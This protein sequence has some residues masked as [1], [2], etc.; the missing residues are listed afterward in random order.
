MRR[1]KIM[2]KIPNLNML[3]TFSRAAHLKSFKDAATELHITPTAVSHQMRKLEDVL[4][5]PLFIRLTR[6]I[7]LTEKGQQL[8][9]VS[10][11]LF[12]ELS[13]TLD[14]L[15]SEDKQ[16]NLTTTVAFASMWLVPKLADFNKQNGDI[17]V[18]I[19]TSDDVVDIKNSQNIDLA[20]RY[21]KD[22]HNTENT[23]VLM[24]ESMGLYASKAYVS[25]LNNNTIPVITTNWK[26]K[27]L[28]NIN[29][30]DCLG[31]SKYLAEITESYDQENH[32]IQAA[33][34]GRG[35]AFVSDILV[36]DYVQN[37]WLVRL[38]GTHSVEGLKY[39]L[40]SGN[41]LSPSMQSNIEYFVT[42]L[43]EQLL[44]ALA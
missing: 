44:E 9:D 16:I 14:D 10:Q 24:T 11:P 41:S 17:K 37:E 31:E 4:G 30:T 36:D 28:P 7:K 22:I 19:I 23:T 21:A 34:L 33:L 18:S 43:K 1:L 39:Y 38:P 8:A 3:Y 20:I 2:A 27:A 13:R 42:W 6:E 26:N 5:Q 12:A 15:R 40:V 32:V 29:F 25:G 35:V